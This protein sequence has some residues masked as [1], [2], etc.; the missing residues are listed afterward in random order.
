MI[1][2]DKYQANKFRFILIFKSGLFG[3]EKILSFGR[4][5][6]GQMWAKSTT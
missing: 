1:I 6:L 5:Y 2:K 4:L 3:I